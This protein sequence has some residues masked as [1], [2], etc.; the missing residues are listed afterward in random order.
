MQTEIIG[1]GVVGQALGAALAAH[2]YTVGYIDTNPD[3]VLALR[4]RGLQ[5]NCPDDALSTATDVSFLCVP[6]PTTDRQAD[7]SLMREAALALGDRLA[8]SSAEYPL[9][10]VK[11]TVLPGTTQTIIIP[12]LEA[13]SGK[14]G[15]KDFGVCVC[16]EYLREKHAYAD[17][18]RPPA[19]VIGV[20]D[21]AAGDALEALFKPFDAP[22]FRLSMRA[23]EL[24][25]YAHNL[26][27]AV[28]IA[29]FN[30]MRGAADA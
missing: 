24:Q 7:Y 3:T 30:E 21:V 10:V 9:V 5:A 13:A 14:Q 4:Q 22:I 12:A 15:G 6:T 11:S 16:P 26:F 20:D 2:G 28:K 23:A 18:L 29:F 25:K 27:N 17:A 8:R 1:A 19:V